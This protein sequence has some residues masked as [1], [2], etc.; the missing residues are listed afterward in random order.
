MSDENIKNDSLSGEGEVVEYEESFAAL[1]EKSS[2]LSVRL[3]PGQRVTSRVISIS[4]DTVYVDLG[5]KSEGMIDLS[6][7][8]DKTGTL[9][10]KEGDEIEAFFLSVQ[11]GMRKLTTLIR[12]Y[13]SVQLKA[14][15]DARETGLAINGAV[16]REVKGGFEISIGGVRCF[17]PLSQIDLKGGRE[18]GIYL[19]QTFPF[20]VLEYEDDGRNIIVSRRT[21]L[22]EEKQARIDKLKE[23]VK[24]GTEVTAKISSVQNFGA[25]IDLGGIDGLI[26]VSEISWARTENPADVLSIGQEVTAKII[27]LDWNKSRL[28]LSIKAMKPDP[29]ANITEKYQVDSRINGTIVRLTHFGAFVRL[30]PGIDG[31]IHISNLGAGR[32]INHPREVVEVDQWVEAYVLSVDPENRKISLSM[33]PKMKPDKIVFPSASELIEGIVEKIMPFGIFLKI[34]NGLTGLIP[35]SEMGTPRGTDHSKMFSVGTSMQA[36]VI[37]VDTEKGKVSLSR[38][39][40]KEKEEEEEFNHY[41]NMVKKEEKF[42]RSLR[43]L[44]EILKAKMEEKKLTG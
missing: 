5:G 33:Q 9:H 25:F 21:L 27:S 35:N 24:V 19:G 30:E 16:K 39:R 3:E 43:T 22:E 29:W 4:E 23:T 28:T 31:L 13:S 15:R 17:C 14:I 20:K 41:K 37:E 7:F 44:G 34:D 26:P 38:K 8:V 32:R 12:G 6:E 2:N 18:G 11:D 36:V 42:S 10:V 40:V 1:L